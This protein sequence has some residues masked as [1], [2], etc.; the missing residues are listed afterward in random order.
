MIRESLNIESLLLRIE[1]SQ[2]RWFGH[3]RRM[4]QERFPKQTLYAE[5]SEKRPVAKTVNKMAGLYRGFWLEPFRT[6]FEQKA[7]CVGESRGKAA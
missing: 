1:R 6:S 4:P 5:V 2:L 3:V 7:V